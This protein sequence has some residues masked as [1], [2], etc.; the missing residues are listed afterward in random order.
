M[1][2]SEFPTAPGLLRFCAGV[3]A[4]YASQ[5]WPLTSHDGTRHERERVFGTR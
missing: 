5:L 4:W 3:Q 1:R 2:R